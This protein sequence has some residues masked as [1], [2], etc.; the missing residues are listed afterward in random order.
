MPDTRPAPRNPVIIIPSRM[1]STR[2]PNK[3]L[4]DILGDPMIVHVWRRAMES[5]I[6]KVV[7]ACDAREIAA[8]V[9]KTG[10]QAVLT[11]PEHPS[12]SDRIWEALNALEGNTTYDAVINVQGDE[13][14]LDP[15]CIRKAFDLL[16]N[17]AVDIGTLAAVIKDEKK[18]TMNQVAKAV[19]DAKPGAAQGRALYFS[20]L[21]APSGE[22][23]MH[24]HIGLYA[25]RRDALARFVAAPPSPLEQR[26]KLEQ[27][28][29][30]ALG[31]HIEVGIVDAVPLGVDTPEDLE[32][33]RKVLEK[34]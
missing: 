2:L 18:K 11:K 8:V 22:G 13:P 34:K 31:M 14:A 27:L 30:L 5:K 33:V 23:V 29:A 21:P 6:G 9:E 1:G 12:G 26:E 7:V 24:H 17:P 10:G 19:I 15:S 16:Q 20:R 3:P 32:E 28:R 4:A 25:Y